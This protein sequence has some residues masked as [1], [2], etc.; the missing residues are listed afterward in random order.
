MFWSLNDVYVHLGITGWNGASQWISRCT[1]RWK[2]A[3]S[4]Q[5]GSDQGQLVLST[6]LSC[7]ELSTKHTLP[8][9]NRCLPTPCM[10]TNSLIFMLTRWASSSRCKGALNSDSARS[11]AVVVRAGILSAMPKDVACTMSIDLHSPNWSCRWPRPDSV[12]MFSANVILENGVLDLSA[13][14]ALASG[15]DP[16]SVAKDWMD[17]IVGVVDDKCEVGRFLDLTFAVPKLSGL[18]SQLC[19]ALS[20]HVEKVYGALSQ[21]KHNKSDRRACVW[22]WL[23]GID[24][25]TPEQIDRFLARYMLAS[26][27]AMR[28]HSCF[29]MATDA[30]HITGMPMSNTLLGNSGGV[31]VLCAPH[32]PSHLVF[33]FA[34]R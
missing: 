21:E 14:I 22:T 29:S 11:Q 10:C 30:A 4:N 19:L 27:A 7:N 31:V 8:W 1:P 5:F 13:I 12:Q 17:L 34:D 16:H 3:Y 32:V 18:F 33:D 24:A 2:H 6:N 23:D 15:V 26:Q 20:V 9:H 28:H 25:K